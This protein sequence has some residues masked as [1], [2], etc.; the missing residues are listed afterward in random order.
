MDRCKSHDF[1]GPMNGMC[2]LSDFSIL[3]YHS[4]YFPYDSPAPN[5][6]RVHPLS[7]VSFLYLIKG[8]HIFCDFPV[9]SYQEYVMTL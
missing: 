7:T 3:L 6:L 5:T 8:V 1:P 9:L 4:T 2:Y